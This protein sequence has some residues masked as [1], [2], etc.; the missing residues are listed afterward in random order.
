MG[1]ALAAIPTEAIK[2]LEQPKVVLVVPGA[3]SPWCGLVQDQSQ[4][5][6]HF[7]L[8]ASANAPSYCLILK[9]P[10]GDISLAADEVLTDVS[11]AEAASDLFTLDLTQ[12]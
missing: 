12:L 9:T 3:K 8:R 5:V 1:A 4:L 10:K 6:A 11:A 7:D 2:Y